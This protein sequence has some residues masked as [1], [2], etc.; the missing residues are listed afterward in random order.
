MKRYLPYILVPLAYCL[1]AVV[2]HRATID[3]ISC[4]VQANGTQACVIYQR[5]ER[6]PIYNWEY[7][8]L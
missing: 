8:G 7:Q 5:G 4:V 3:D 6:E 1:G 2:H